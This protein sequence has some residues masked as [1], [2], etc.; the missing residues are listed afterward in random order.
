MNTTRLQFGL[1]E[2]TASPRQHASRPKVPSLS[3][4]LETL[5]KSSHDQGQA[6]VSISRASEEGESF[7]HR[8]LSAATVGEGGGNGEAAAKVASANISK[9]SLKPSIGCGETA[10]LL[11]NIHLKTP[12]RYARKGALPGY[13]VGGHWYFRASEL[14]S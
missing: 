3:R 10:R 12:Q 14:D 1:R 5:S 6:P 7:T 9:H 13:H 11:G 4:P 8:P 2:N